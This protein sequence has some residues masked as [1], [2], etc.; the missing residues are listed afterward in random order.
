MIVGSA[1]GGYLFDRGPGLPFLAS[2]VLIVA[3]IALALAFFRMKPD[4]PGLAP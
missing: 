3:S 4:A 2:S 1:V